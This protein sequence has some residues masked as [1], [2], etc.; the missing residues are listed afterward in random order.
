M[1]TETAS[2]F[3]GSSYILTLE[4]SLTETI[5]NEVGALSRRLEEG[6]ERRNKAVQDVLEKHR[7]TTSSAEDH[8]QRC[9]EEL[10]VELV[11]L[12]SAFDD[13]LM[14]LERQS[15]DLERKIEAILGRT[16]LLHRD[17]RMMA[18]ELDQQLVNFEKSMETLRLS[19]EQSLGE[20]RESHEH[21]VHS[22]ITSRRDSLEFAARSRER[23]GTRVMELGEALRAES[24]VPGPRPLEGSAAGS[25]Q[26][27]AWRHPVAAL[28]SWFRR[29]RDRIALSRLE[30]R[31]GEL[32][33]EI[34]EHKERSAR[35]SEFLRQAWLQEKELF[36][37]AR[38]NEHPEV[39]ANGSGVR[40][41]RA[42]LEVSG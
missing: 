23:F 37:S 32:E 24:R 9:I 2:R 27:S 40:D 21:H 16:D 29:L 33:Q 38:R 20:L 14:E 3:S 7:Q 10:G 35:R 15:C 26:R 8:I 19:S 22:L 36:P 1:L 39:K 30:S 13:R 17:S 34:R 31:V 6:Q 41:L 18:E 11:Q 4:R 12:R 28:R 42:L 25:T 5:R